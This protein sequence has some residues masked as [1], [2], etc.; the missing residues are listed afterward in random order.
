MN[1]E[2]QRA[3]NALAI[4]QN[5]LPIALRAKD[6]GKVEQTKEEKKTES[7]NE[8]KEISSNQEP[9]SVN[10]KKDETSY[11]LGTSEMEQSDDDHK[12]MEQLRKERVEKDLDQVIYISI[13]ETPTNILFYSPSTKYLTIKNGILFISYKFKY[14]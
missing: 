2:E 1:P 7:K 11:D 13:S 14:R 5:K 9:S 12:K 10:I 3:A 8:N 4:F 6:A